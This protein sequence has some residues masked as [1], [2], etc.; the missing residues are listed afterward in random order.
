MESVL[1]W[2]LGVRQG[3]STCSGP[4]LTVAPVSIPKCVLTPRLSQHG[5]YLLQSLCLHPGS[6]LPLPALS[7][8]SFR[9]PSFWFWYNPTISATRSWSS[10]SPFLGFLSHSPTTRLPHAPVFSVGHVHC[11]IFSVSSGCFQ[12]PLAVLFLIAKLETFPSAM[13][14]SG[15]DLPFGDKT[16]QNS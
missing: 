3:E 4:C 10:F 7:F 14:W 6:S 13:P 11:T 12:M 1:E 15:H 2:G 8:S 9:F 5:K 16:S